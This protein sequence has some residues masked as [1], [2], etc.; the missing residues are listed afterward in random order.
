MLRAGL[1]RFVERGGRWEK[2]DKV[3][4]KSGKLDNP[5]KGKIIN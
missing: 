5:K 3:K 2:A 1:M 4:E